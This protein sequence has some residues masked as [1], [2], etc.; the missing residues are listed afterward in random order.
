[1]TK[2]DTVLVSMY[3]ESG[4]WYDRIAAYDANGQFLRMLLS[5][6]RYAARLYSNE[7]VVTGVSYIRTHCKRTTPNLYIQP[8]AVPHRVRPPVRVYGGQ[9]DFVNGTFESKYDS[10]GAI[11]DPP[12]IYN[13]EP[14][15][16]VTTRGYNSFLFFAGG[17]SLNSLVEC[18]CDIQLYVDQQTKATRS[19]IAGIEM[20]MTASKAYST[21]DLL[22]VGDTLYKAATAIASGATL[23]P[24]T[25][26]N[27][28]TVAE[29]L[30]LLANA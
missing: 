28:T 8:D 20:S 16:L 29:Q 24:G 15:D 14:I 22:I 6:S 11:L 1:M 5:A 3:A 21:G 23:T 10:T 2:Y 9:A 26:V 7:V 19:L 13:T 25:N 18:R 30:I 17:K 12:T 27:E 4:R